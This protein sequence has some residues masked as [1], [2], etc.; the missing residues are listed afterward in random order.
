MIS[1]EEEMSIKITGLNEV[2]KK[3]NDLQKKAKALDGKHQVPFSELFN[4]SF[5]RRYTNFDSIEALIKA[6]GFKFE[7]MDDFTAIPDQEWD[8]HIAKTTKFSNWQ[9]MMSEAGAEW[10]K[11]QLGF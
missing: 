11:K 10:A 1:Q 5:M 2:Q 4:A 6:G 8:D 7:T 9:E 3:L